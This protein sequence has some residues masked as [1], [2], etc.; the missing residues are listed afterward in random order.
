MANVIKFLRDMFDLGC[1][2]VPPKDI[3]RVDD[4]KKMSKKQI[5]NYMIYSL[6]RIFIL[7]KQ[8]GYIT[9]S[10]EY[11]LVSTSYLEANRE[12]KQRRLFF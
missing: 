2:Y 6:V 12:L 1:V 7:D 3:Q 8:E 11:F 9:R 5:Q 10:F 4:F